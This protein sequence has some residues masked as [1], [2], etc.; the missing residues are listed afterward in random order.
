MKDFSAF[1]RFFDHIYILSLHRARERQA[2]IK[3]NLAGLNYEFF[4]GADKLDHPMH[5]M[6]SEG[7]YDETLAIK[8]HR[9]HK[10]L[11]VGQVCC[12][13]SHKRI[14]EDVIRRH[15]KKVL[16]LED[17][18]TTTP[19]LDHAAAS[20]MSELP[21][22]WELLYLDYNKNEQPHRLKQS[23][24]HVQKLLGGLTWSHKT[25]S[26]LYPKRVSKHIATSGYHDY[27]SAYAITAG[28]AEKLLKLQT[29]I[30]Y[31]ADNLLATACT[32]QAVKGYIAIPK[33]F[34]QLSQG[35]GKF[36]T[37]FVD[38]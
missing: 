29:P 19:D 4:W 15:F 22:N 1:N 10:P 24:Y 11:S 25:I 13:W 33:L 36:T 27:T 30:H 3:T 38:D 32:T 7:V 23:W 31:L 14:Y 20:V 12:S 2:A 9:Y 18:V 21:A 37:S 26:H 16:I 28:A 6:L 34:S 8:N 5:H 35:D 17:D